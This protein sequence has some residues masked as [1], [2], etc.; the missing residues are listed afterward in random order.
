MTEIGYFS[1]KLMT[2]KSSIQKTLGIH[3]EQRGSML[4]EDIFRFDFS[5]QSKVSDKELK[6]VEVIKM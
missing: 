1:A 5:H 3:I 6:N 2:G 4:T